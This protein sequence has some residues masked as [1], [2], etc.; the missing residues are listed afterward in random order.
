MDRLKGDKKRVT[1]KSL[2][3]LLAK[4]RVPKELVTDQQLAGVLINRGNPGPL[5][6]KDGTIIRGI[7]GS[8]SIMTP[9]AVI[10]HRNHKDEIIGFKIATE[11][12]IRAEIWTTEKRGK[13]G[14]VIKDKNCKSEL[15]YHRRLIPHPRGLKNLRLRVMQC[16]GNRLTWERALTDAEI[17][18]LGLKS[19]AEVK[20]LRKDH[21]KAVKLHEKEISK[22]KA[23]ESELTLTKP[24][25]A[26]AIPTSPVISL[27]K[28]YTGLPPH[29]KRLTNANGT[30]IS[31]VFKGDLLYVPLRKVAGA[32][33]GH[34]K[35]CK[36]SQAASG[37]SYWFRV[38]A[39]KSAGEIELKL[40]EYKLPKLEDDKKPTEQQEWLIKIWE[41]RPI[42]ADDI[43]WLLEQSRRHDQPSHSVK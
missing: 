18:E 43:A 4:A 40:E 19:N 41:Q 39:I 23:A 32:E 5:T 16:T 27:R 20:R 26:S 17:I 31:R 36:R 28:I 24:E 34:G 8:A 13:N 25:V 7:S 15:E 29:A 33:K 38:S 9:M 30:D 2:R 6:R 12:F 10:P 21:E 14:A 3:A 42:S 11:T 1:D 37:G 35:F 22:A